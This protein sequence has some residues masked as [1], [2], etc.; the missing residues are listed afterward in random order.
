GFTTHALSSPLLLPPFPNGDFLYIGDSSSEGDVVVA[1]LKSDGT[2]R[3]SFGEGGFITHDFG[4]DER[5]I[6]ASI[7]ELGR[8]ILLHKADGAY[9]VT[10]FL[11]SG[12]ID[13][14]GG[15]VYQNP[16]GGR[17]EYH[18]VLIQ[19]NGRI[20]AVGETGS[21]GAP[22]HIMLSALKV[23]G[24]SDTT[25]QFSR[26]NP[27]VDLP[28]I[29]RATT[30][31]HRGNILIAAQ[32]SDPENESSWDFLLLRYDANGNVFNFSG[33]GDQGWPLTTITNRSD[34]PQVIAV[35]PD[36]KILVG[37][38]ANTESSIDFALVRYLPDG[39]VDPAFSG[40]VVTTD[41]KG[42]QK[43]DKITDLTVLPDGKILV[44]GTQQETVVSESFS[45][46]VRYLPDGRLDTTFGANGVQSVRPSTRLFIRPDGKIV[47]GGTIN[48][49]G[50]L[51]FNVARYLPNGSRD[52]SFASPGG[53]LTIEFE[54]SAGMSDMLMEPDGSLV[55]AG[56]QYGDPS[57]FAMAR[58]RPEGSLDQSFS[59]DGRA[60]FPV[61]TVRQA[62]ANALTL[63]HE[64][65]GYILAGGAEAEI[66]DMQLTML[67]VKR[68][69][70]ENNP[71]LA[72][73]E[74]YSMAAGTTLHVAAP[75]ILA[76]D[77]DPDG[78]MLTVTVYAYPENGE[79]NLNLDGSF[80]YT[81]LNGFVGTDAFGYTVWDGNRRNDVGIVHIE[82]IGDPVNNPPLVRADNIT[83]AQDT[84]FSLPA[85]GVLAN[86]EDAD[87]NELTAVLST[88]PAHGTLSLA[89]DGSLTYIPDSGF[90]GFDAFTYQADDGSKL[91]EP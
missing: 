41:I 14:G 55:L 54:G 27:L 70:G 40:G 29:A 57:Q 86:D 80:T 52:N 73:A 89:A 58:V 85:P 43:I 9:K 7:D 23:N 76:N 33:L 19:L 4:E 26:T 44:L 22:P 79:F 1:L 69:K 47:V 72:G 31:D 39:T 28:G 8:I 50:K 77:Q 5:V 6:D 18:D 81:P 62:C 78:D 84:P 21:K 42:E 49:D 11:P 68:L 38:Y 25:F 82:V 24:R 53:Q 34:V 83:L 12:R 71:P 75:G 65:K 56:C 46:L 32:V 87:G 91:S 74:N 63:D 3:E 48:V 61:D 60:T 88:S 10:R 51:M 13:G 35:Q 30:L 67:K 45:V 2:A 16:R 15:H 59:A 17:D 66:A 20:L 37:G 64:H 90:I 36:D